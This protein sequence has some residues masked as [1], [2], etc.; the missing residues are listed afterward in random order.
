MPKAAPLVALVEPVVQPEVPA[1]LAAARSQSGV[2]V[3]HLARLP[4]L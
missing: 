1:A 3:L 2:A 4:L